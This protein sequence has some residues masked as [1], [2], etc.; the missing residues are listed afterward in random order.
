MCIIYL[1]AKILHINTKINLKP[2]NPLHG[3]QYNIFDDFINISFLFYTD[4]CK[5]AVNFC[6]DAC[7][8]SGKEERLR[9]FDYENQQ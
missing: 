4:E 3:T 1:V 5:V 7:F 6:R 2:R 8:V 9:N